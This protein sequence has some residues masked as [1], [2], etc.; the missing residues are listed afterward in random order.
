M[1]RRSDSIPGYLPVL[2]GIRALSVVLIWV[3]HVWQQ[4]WV[5]WNIKTPDGSTLF[6]LSVFQQC[7]YVAVDVFFVLSGFCLFYPIARSMF[8]EG[9]PINWKDFYI[10]RAKKILPSYFFILLVFFFVKDL[11]YMNTYDFKEGFRQFAKAMTFTSTTDVMS[12]GGLVATSWTLCVEVQFY[13]LFPVIAWLFRKKPVLSCLGIGVLSV[14]FRLWAV[15][16]MTLGSVA[17]GVVF[18]YLDL[19]AYGMIAAYA[20]VW[21]KKNLNKMDK[22]KLPMTLIAIVCLYVIYLYMK[23]ML[24]ANVPGLDSP[25]LQ[26]F[27]YRPLLDLPIALFIFV[28]CFSFNFWQKGIWGNR[29][30]VFLST[31]SYNFYLWHQNI[32]IYMKRHPVT[33]LFTLED[34]AN[35]T[36]EPMIW[37]TLVTLAISLIIATA[38]TYLLEKPM[39][40]YGFVGY[41]KHIANKL[42]RK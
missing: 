28:S 13:L 37:Y 3:F 7:G 38:V 24:R 40:Q 15:T 5:W 11:G 32:H 14:L 6:S 2:D 8:G 33:S 34:A 26:R 30:F 20:V 18:F 10:K 25:A 29:L 22:L 39:Y 19:F 17:Q 4:S 42:K 9:K 35:H 12:Y 21:A 27:V 16:N 36:H 41:F 31:I 1:K 23:W